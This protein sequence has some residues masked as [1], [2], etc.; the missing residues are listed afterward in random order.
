MGIG[1]ASMRNVTIVTLAGA[2]HAFTDRIGS[3]SPKSD[4]QDDTPTIIDLL[5]QGKVANRTIPPR[6]GHCRS[7]FT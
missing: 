5:C 4:R 6:C 1:R 3:I 2:N 7:R